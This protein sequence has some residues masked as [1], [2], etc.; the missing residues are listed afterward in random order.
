[1]KKQ[2][3]IFR[4]GLILACALLTTAGYICP[5]AYAEEASSSP[6]SA[7][8]Q[9]IAAVFRFAVQSASATDATPLSLQACRDNAQSAADGTAAQNNLAVDPL[10]LDAISDELQQKL[11]KKMSVMVDPDPNTVPVGA[12]TINGCVFQAEKGNKAERMIGFGLGASQLEAHVVLLSKT[13]TGFTPVDSFDVQV[14]GRAILP[15]AGPAGVAVHAAKEFRE[16]L[17][18]DA[19][20]LADQI[21][22]KL[23]NDMKQQAS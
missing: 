2:I 4:S 22:K 9:P 7:V 23:N 12:L 8:Q 13:E 20:K 6:G 15:P 16:T 19:K 21:V 11:S 1:M 3:A 17:T 14:K 18:A 10:I 5:R